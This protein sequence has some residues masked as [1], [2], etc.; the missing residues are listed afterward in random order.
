MGKF[1]LRKKEMLKRRD[2]LENQYVEKYPETPNQSPK[3]ARQSKAAAMILDK[4]LKN[5]DKEVEELQVKAKDMLNK[6][7]AYRKNRS[8]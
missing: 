7:N 5:I 2:L 8:G 1:L 6:L 4:Q 3:K